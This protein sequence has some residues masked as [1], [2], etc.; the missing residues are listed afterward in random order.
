MFII[1]SCLSSFHLSELH[2]ILEGLLG[3]P[4]RLLHVAAVHAVH[5]RD[6]VHQDT[7]LSSGA[8]SICSTQLH[9]PNFHTVR[10][11]SSHYRQT[12][13]RSR[14]EW[15]QTCPP[16][17]LGM[18]PLKNKPANVPG[19]V[20]AHFGFFWKEFIPI[21]QVEL[22]GATTSP[23]IDTRDDA[24][25]GRVEAPFI[26]PKNAPAIVPPPPGCASLAWIRF[27]YFERSVR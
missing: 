22:C 14:G 24:E 6:Q 26:F 15:G 19:G 1:H 17:S 16:P 7:Q 8:V 3:V 9:T 25:R 10:G 13:W 18:R 21:W 4:L 12:P 20:Y 5:H 11:L 2:D 27:N 23:G